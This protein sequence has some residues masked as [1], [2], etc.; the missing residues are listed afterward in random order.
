MFKP[1]LLTVFTLST[2][3]LGAQPRNFTQME[4]ADEHFEYGNYLFAIQAYKQELKKDPDNLKAK[5][6]LGV[7][8]LNTRVSR[9][10]AIPYLEEVSRKPKIDGEVWFYLA[11]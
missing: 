3:F 4:D 5:F 9:E 11:R 10:D 6:R 2:L 7:C 1:F 8:Y